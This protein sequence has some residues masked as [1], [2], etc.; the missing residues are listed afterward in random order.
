MEPLALTFY[1]MFL[2]EGQSNKISGSRSFGILGIFAVGK[3]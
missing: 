1:V 3:G 2:T